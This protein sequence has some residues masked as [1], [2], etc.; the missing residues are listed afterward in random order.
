MRVAVIPVIAGL[1]IGAIAS[2]LAYFGN[3]GNMGFCGACFLRDIS[4]AIGL[5]RASI[6]QY[7][8]PEIIGLVFGAFI[9]SM[10]FKEFRPRG[11]SS[12]LMRFFLG[13]FASIGA[14]VFLGCPW[15]AWIRLGGGDLS[16]IAGIVGLFVGIFI[17]SIFLKNGY[18]LGKSKNVSKLESLL[19]PIFMLVL[20][21]FLV[22]KFSF[23]E[24]L[25]IFFSQKGPGSNHANIVISI[26]A[27]LIIGVLTQRSRFCTIAA[28]RDTILFKDT[29]LLQGV[30]ALFVGVFVMNLILGQFHLGFTNQPIAHN[31][32]VWNFL[33]MVLCGLA[34]AL[35]G[36]CP[37]RQLTLSGEGDSDAGI[38][39]IGMIVG[40]AFS[41]N[42][43]LASSG[44]GVSVFGPYMVIIGL[45]FCLI[46]GFFAKER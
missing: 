22:T 29:H 33:S 44:A 39:V 10:F 15:R 3:P 45:L 16:A 19:I 32:I 13:V 34:F 14:L 43:A 8:R 4:G 41:H 40:A 26:I 38:F 36:G 12:P 20:F 35:A 18:S 17:A 25:P 9:S 31:D 42:F 1:A 6:V 24:N 27:G 2:L 28:F 21:V 30:L 23:G 46:L 7:I 11:G 37:G 5:H